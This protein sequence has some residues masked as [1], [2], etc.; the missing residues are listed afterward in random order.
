MS[1]NGAQIKRLASQELRQKRGDRRQGPSP[2]PV[3]SCPWASSC[4]S[5]CYSHRS[6]TR[7]P[8]PE[9]CKTW[10]PSSWSHLP[11]HSSSWACRF[12]S[13]IPS[14]L[15]SA[16]SRWC[17]RIHRNLSV[18]ELIDRNR[19]TVFKIDVLRWVSFWRALKV[20]LFSSNPRRQSKNIEM[21]YKTPIKLVYGLYCMARHAALCSLV[22][23]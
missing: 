11:T 22:K 13:A 7:W 21:E 6:A 3:H 8:S 23:L 15:V 2:E 19:R 20:Q 18:C 14:T 10:P 4:P 12:S 17:T 5:C 16:D 9:S 1:R